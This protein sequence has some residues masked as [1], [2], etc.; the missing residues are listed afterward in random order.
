MET[1]SE[2]LEATLEERG[3]RYGPYIEQS[4]VSQNI[5]KAI[6]DSNNYEDMPADMQG[7]L[8]MIAEKLSR[9]LTGD[10]YYIDNWHDI[11]GY[12]ALVEKRLIKLEQDRAQVAL[13]F[14]AEPDNINTERFGF[15]ISGRTMAPGSQ[16][17]E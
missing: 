14:V 6:R 3:G 10:M 17:A 16:K 1:S 2:K 11:A 15:K 9:A 12:A 13:P 7:C 5:Q 8:Q 4:R